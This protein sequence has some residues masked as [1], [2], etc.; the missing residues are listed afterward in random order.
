MTGV[1]KNV[2]HIITPE[3]KQPLGDITQSITVARTRDACRD[4]CL[5]LLRRHTWI[6][7]TQ[8]HQS[9]LKLLNTAG[10]Q[11]SGEFNPPC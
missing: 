10:A 3:K 4:A 1:T 8:L 2:F 7:K 9:G 6:K 5:A 11:L